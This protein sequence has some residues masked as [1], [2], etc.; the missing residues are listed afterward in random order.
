MTLPPVTQREFHFPV[1][2]TLMSTTDLHSHIAYANAAFV[3]VSGFT[4]DELIG[5]AHRVVRHPDMPRQAFADLW[6]TLR[7]GQAWTALVKNRRRDGDHYWVR[8]NVAPVVRQGQVQGFI[9]VRTRPGREEVEQ[10]ESVYRALR[11]GRLRGLRFHRGLLLRRGWQG[12]LDRLQTVSV[13]LRLRLGLWPLVLL[14]LPAAA[15]LGLPE[16][17]LPPLAILLLVAGLLLDRWLQQQIA[18]P[19]ERVAAQAAAVAS[20]CFDSELR[21]PRVD[22]IGMTLRSLNQAGL[23]LRA[24]VAD[25]GSQLDTLRA[26]AKSMEQSSGE[27]GERTEQTSR[28]LAEARQSLCGLRD[29]IASNAQLAGDAHRGAAQMDDSARHSGKLA[30][31]LEAQMQ[32]IHASSREIGEIAS[33]IDAIA[34]QTN[35][36]AL[37]AAVEAA[38]AGPQGRGFAVVAAE[39]RQLAQRSQSAA[40]QVKQLI[41][42]SS[43]RVQRGADLAVASRAA[44]ESLLDQVRDMRERVGSMRHA[45]G[46]QAQAV[47]TLQ[48]RVDVLEQASQ[49]NASSAEHSAQHAQTLREQ[50][51]Q[52]GHSLRVFRHA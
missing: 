44:T 35:L 18:R 29:G 3:N 40:R 20:G 4:R 32:G 23:N 51:E 1:D 39:V 9:S 37:N 31:E 13:S 26:V 34:F 5:E 11:E 30:S 46:T 47:D 19:L 33:L 43:L 42:D 41:A 24:L 21:L 25:A 6:A 15:G 17:S 8:A 45:A 36:L 12:L 52:L 28:R 48:E 49:H 7:S 38:R 22:A 2:A 10:A 27:L 16:P 14:A 50:V